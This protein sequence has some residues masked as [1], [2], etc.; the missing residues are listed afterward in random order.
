MV[1]VAASALFSTM[2]SALRQQ[3]LAATR[4]QQFADRASIFRDGDP[5]DGLYVIVEGRVVISAM[6]SAT[7][8]RMFSRLE[9]GDFFGEMAVLD[10]Q[11]RS[12]TATAEGLTTLAF[13]PRETMATLFRAS[14]DL[15]LHFAQIISERLRT[16]NRHYLREVLE[17][18]RLAAVGR[19][20][21]AIVHDLKNPLSIISMAAALWLRK[22]DAPESRA[23]AYQRITTQV[24]RISHL[25][26][27]VLEYARGQR[28]RPV[29][30]PADYAAFIRQ[31][32]E[33]LQQDA[34][35]KA[36][37]IACVNPPPSLPVAIDDS[38]L[39]R[40]MANLAYNAM[41]AMPGGGR[42]LLR[43]EVGERE[44]ITE[45]EDTGPGLPAEILGRL[46]EP[47][48][49]HGKEHGTGLGLSIVKCIIEEH[50]GQIS[51]RNQP[52]GGAVFRFT[53]PRS[54]LADVSPAPQTPPPAAG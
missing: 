10:E 26:N 34:E 8:R 21:S 43:F 32:I 52:G 16:F 20:A 48:A 37:T 47:F 18:E 28:T 49:T 15:A 50:G 40:A 38:R 6:V 9:P 3:M 14:P 30:K 35:L 12:A 25:V 7:E 41:D 13:L 39:G 19:F 36:A 53:L 1:P 23:L 51:A 33:R 17:A 4:L 5:G 46:F 42:I 2:P 22:H 54:D 31:I 11:P 24:E 29:L 45:V 44:I 27:D